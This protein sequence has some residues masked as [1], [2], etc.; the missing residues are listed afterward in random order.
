MNALITSLSNSLASTQQQLNLLHQKLDSLDLTHSSVAEKVALYQQ[1]E[2]L[3]AHAFMIQHSQAVK[4]LRSH[5]THIRHAEAAIHIVNQTLYDQSP[6]EID[7]SLVNSITL[8]L[9]GEYMDGDEE[10]HNIRFKFGT[11]TQI[12]WRT[13][14]FITYLANKHLDHSPFSRAAIAQHIAHAIPEYDSPY[15]W[16]NMTYLEKQEQ[17]H[18][19]DNFITIDYTH[20]TI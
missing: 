19:G 5:V 1:I 12:Q 3:V 15:E 18:I 16:L 11:K 4:A 6:I 20:L 14:R 9:I 7:S 2:S 8:H 13:E 17:L 10:S